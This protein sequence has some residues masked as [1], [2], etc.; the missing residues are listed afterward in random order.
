MFLEVLRDFKNVV[1]YRLGGLR[2][3]EYLRRNGLMEEEIKRLIVKIGLESSDERTDKK[4]G[5]RSQAGNFATVA[6]R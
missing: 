4:I 2:V 5:A 6:Q 1:S 3:F